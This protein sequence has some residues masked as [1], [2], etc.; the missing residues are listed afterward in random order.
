M[1]LPLKIVYS[2]L[3]Q[4]ADEVKTTIALIRH[5]VT[6]RY[7]QGMPRV[8]LRLWGKIEDQLD[9]PPAELELTTAQWNLIYEASQAAHWP[10]PWA[11]LALTFLTALDEAE[12]QA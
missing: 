11:R 1:R 10:V 7:P 5:A 6:Q 3:P 8:E 2:R 4:D 9:E 12:R